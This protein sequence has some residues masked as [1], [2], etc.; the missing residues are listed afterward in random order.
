MFV[1]DLKTRKVFVFQ[2]LF[3]GFAPSRAIGFPIVF[4]LIFMFFKTIPLDSF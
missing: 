1:N 2:Y 4:S 3:N